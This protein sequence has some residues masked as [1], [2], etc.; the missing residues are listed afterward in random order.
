MRR[1]CNDST[2]ASS[3]DLP[4]SIYDPND[5][6]MS[7]ADR[8]ALLATLDDVVPGNW[9]LRPP[10]LHTGLD[11]VR[12]NRVEGLSV[13]LGA[14]AT[15][16]TGTAADATVRL[17]LADLVPNAELGLTRTRGATNPTTLRIAAYHRLAVANDDWGN[18][19]GFGASLAA[20]LYGRDE[21][22][23]YRS[24]GVAVQGTRPADALLDPDA[25]PVSHW[26]PLAL[27]RGAAL[28]WRVFAEDQRGANAE[29]GRGVIGPRYVANI[30]AD[31]LTTAG[32]GG[33][34]A[35]TFGADPAGLRVVVR[36]RG[37]GAVAHYADGAADTRTAPYA[38]GLFDVTASRPLG[39]VTA[40]VTAATGGIAGG[41]VPVQRLFYLGG[42]QTVRG[43]FPRAT[44]EGY[45]GREFWLAR[46]ELGLGTGTL[47][48]PVVFFDAGRA[49]AQAFA[50]GATLRGVGAG[51]VFLDGLVRVEGARGLGEQRGGR[52]DVSLGGRF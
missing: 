49:G 19:L 39:P 45:V 36:A 29:L 35:R 26:N 13:G 37:E 24:W 32:L 42:L 47:A 21:G 22:F 2:L 8:A 20:A 14:T 43:N 25:S 5:T 34:L 7:A 40:S 23:Y 4:K 12:F 16:P 30:A 17:G 28:G 11:L 6:P 3:P 10:R 9:P 15:L 27:V 46:S 44:G 41:R 38:R 33:E 18:P 51:V 50:R 52:V 1:P 48:R 31:R